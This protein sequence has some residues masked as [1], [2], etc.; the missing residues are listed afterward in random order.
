[1]EPQIKDGSLLLVNRLI[2]KCKKPKVG[3]IVVFASPLDGKFLCKRIRSYDESED[4]CELAG[5][6]IHD[7]MDSRRFGKIK[8]KQILGRV[9]I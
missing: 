9:I 6:N 4:T 2:Y 1:M 8:R 7:S 5:D 3:E